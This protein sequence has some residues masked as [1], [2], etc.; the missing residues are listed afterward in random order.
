MERPR[1]WIGVSSVISPGSSSPLA[2]ASARRAVSSAANRATLSAASAGLIMSIRQPVNLAAKRA[3]CPS[4]PIAKDNC[5]SGTTTIA[6]FP[7]SLS[8]TNSTLTGR[9]GLNALAMNSLG[10]GLHSTISIFSPPNSL[11]IDWILT[12][13]IPTQAPTGSTPG[14]RAATATLEREPGSRAMAFISTV[15]LYI[16]GTSSSKR[17]RSIAQWVRETMI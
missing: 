3:F 14:C 2:R 5:F 10:S 6:V 16:S 13:R 4:R 15:P 11:T 12:P 1:T 7:I 8:S 9:A 17:R